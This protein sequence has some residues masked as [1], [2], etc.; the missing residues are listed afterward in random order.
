MKLNTKAKLT[1]EQTSTKSLTDNNG[2]YD[3]MR[4]EYQFLIDREKKKIVQTFML[5]K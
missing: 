1:N 3:I 5:K 2:N 4:E